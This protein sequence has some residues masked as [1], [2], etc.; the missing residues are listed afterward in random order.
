MSSRF[1]E[2]YTDVVDSIFLLL[3]KMAD[4]EYNIYCIEFYISSKD[5]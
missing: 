4:L 5:L 2:H 1:L 3:N